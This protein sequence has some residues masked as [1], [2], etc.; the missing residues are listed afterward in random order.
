MKRFKNILVVVDQTH[1]DDVFLYRAANLAASNKGRLKIVGVSETV[2]GLLAKKLTSRF[3]VDVES[4]VREKKL[5]QLKRIESR[6]KELVPVTTRLLEGTPFI[7]IIREVRR[8]RHDLVVVQTAHTGSIS[9]GL[10]GSTEIRLLRKCPCPVWIFRRE[11]MDRFNRI[12]AAINVNATGQEEHD[13]NRK[14]LELSCALST[15]DQSELHIIHCW[16]VVGESILQ[17]RGGFDGDMDA[18]VHEIEAAVTE[19]LQDCL[20]PF[21]AIN[22]NMKVH[23]IK[24]SPDVLVPELVSKEEIGLLVMGTVARSGISGLLIGNTAEK[25]VNEVSCSLLAVKPEGFVCPIEA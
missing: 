24:G 13:L 9:T 12:L 10:F 11:G 8:D 7:E 20:K 17:A 2:P 1:R 21:K 23:L 22:P 4:L 19:Q 3:Q 5:T 14:I 25:I 18:Y 16:H 6:Y 15:I